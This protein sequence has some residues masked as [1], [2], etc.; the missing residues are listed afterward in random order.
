MTHGR[1]LHVG[2]DDVDLAELRR[3]ARERREPRA[4]NAVIVGEE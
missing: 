4:V 1:L 2:G 3:D